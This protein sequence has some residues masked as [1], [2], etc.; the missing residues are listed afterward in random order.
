MKKS[1]DL[2]GRRGLKHLAEEHAYIEAVIIMMHADR[3]IEVTELVD[4]QDR[5]NS[6]PKL[7]NLSEEN[8]T[9]LLHRS[10]ADLE[11]EGAEAR[12]IAVAEALPTPQQRLSALEMALS[13]SSSDNKITESEHAVI[14]K[15]K[16]AFELS[17]EQVSEITKSF[18]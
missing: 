11:Q 12:I 16:E 5:L 14:E 15:M 1:E 13:I 2:S 10:V 7:N 4:L 3:V 17:E 9:T 18:S 8:L 6:H